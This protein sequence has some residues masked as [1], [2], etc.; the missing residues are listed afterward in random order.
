MLKTRYQ[1]KK[2]KRL[3]S[4][5]MVSVDVEHHV[6]IRNHARQESAKGQRTNSTVST[7]TKAIKE[8]KKKEICDNQKEL[9]FK[10]K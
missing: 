9:H 7:T 6:Y 10:E 3:H 1:K 8:N 4:F 2:A 5:G